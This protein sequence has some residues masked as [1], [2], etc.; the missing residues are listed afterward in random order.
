M[1]VIKYTFLNYIPLIFGILVMLAGIISFFDDKNV[2]VALVRFLISLIIYVYFMSRALR[3]EYVKAPIILGIIITLLGVLG[4]LVSY[5]KKYIV[6]YYSFFIVGAATSIAF[7]Y[8]SYQRRCKN[9]GKW[10]AL[11]EINRE[12]IDKEDTVIK[13]NL[14]ETRRDSKGH[15]FQTIDREVVVPAYRLT[16]EVT[17]ECR[18]CHEIYTYEDTEK[19]EK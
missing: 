11:V 10:N 7:I 2:G 6:V 8:K 9:C 17:D 12:I 4:L 15:V 14:R 18:Y 5:D 13:K 1:K 16:Y 19:V 3:K